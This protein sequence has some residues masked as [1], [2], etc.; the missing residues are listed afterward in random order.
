[1]AT[2]LFIAQQTLKKIAEISLSD[3]EAQVALLARSDPH[4]DVRIAACKTLEALRAVSQIELLR[5]LA[6]NDANAG[7]RAQA[8]DS[9][10]ALRNT[11]DSSTDDSDTDGEKNRSPFVTKKTEIGEPE[12]PPSERD[13]YKTPELMA[14]R[15][16]PETRS[17]GLGIGTMGGFGIAALDVRGKIDTGSA[18][19]PWVGLE[20][21]GGWTPPN[22]YQLTAG[23]VGKVNEEKNKW[24]I[25]SVAASVLLYFHR[26]HYLP[27]RSGWDLGRSVYFMLGYGFEHLNHEGFFSWGVEAGILYQPFIEQNIEKLVDC[28]NQLECQD[29]EFWPVI[30]YVGFSL[31]FYLV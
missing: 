3:K 12:F 18:V 26:M 22:G 19:L 14:S 20:P 27:I 7:V 30:P 2:A 1:M 17:F 29:N 11:G 23:P 8:A 5:E 24:R 6:E 31:H 10:A 21:G 4:P 9:A 25:V 13:K 28:G 16:E 15:P